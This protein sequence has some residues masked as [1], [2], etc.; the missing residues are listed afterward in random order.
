MKPL[1]LVDVDGVLNCFG[2][3]WSPE[4]E[5]R[6]FEPLRIYDGAYTIRCRKGLRAQLARLAEHFE[7]HWCTM[8]EGEAHPFFGG[9]LG[10][11]DE[12]WPYIDWSA[13]FAAEDRTWKLTDVRQTFADSDRAIAWV[14][15]D[16]KWDAFEWARERTVDDGIPTM[17]VR[18]NPVQ[19]LTD[20]NVDQL[21]QFAES[22]Q[23]A[24]EP[25]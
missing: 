17:L 12:P 4:Y 7:M 16:L 9:W 22:V 8:W 14:D 18:T 15:D 25:A 6:E 5:A 1:L 11:G 3:L 23:T 24:A 21:V 2:S 10:L 13:S 20:E 19:G